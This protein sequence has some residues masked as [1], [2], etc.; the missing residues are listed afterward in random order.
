[1]SIT[2]KRGEIYRIVFPYISD[3]RHKDKPQEKFVLILQGGARFDRHKKVAGLII[4]SKDYHSEDITV[5]LDVGIVQALPLVSYVLC[6]QPHTF[7]KKLFEGRQPCGQ[8]PF[9]KMNEIDEKL[10]IGLCMGLE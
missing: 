9:E 1:M 2:L 8:L 3:E 6:F 7:D 10:Y 4:T 5:K